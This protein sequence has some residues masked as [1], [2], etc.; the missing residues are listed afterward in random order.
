MFKNIMVP[1]DLAHE[2]RLEKTMNTA[3]DL[4]K[5][6]GATV[7]VVG[8]TTSQPSSVAHNPKEF[9]EKLEAFAK[10][11]SDALGVPIAAKSYV[12]HDPAIDLE[13][14]LQKA[15][16]E[17]GCDLVV[18]G[19]HVPGFGEFIFSSNAGYLASHSEMSVFVVR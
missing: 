13:D 7:T 16:A 10:K 6:Y 19:S 3:S 1:V 5:H 15:E 4:G 9:H 18:M 17:T 14:S 2:D 8:V 12:A 11:Y